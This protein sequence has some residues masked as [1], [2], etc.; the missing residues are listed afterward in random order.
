MGSTAG[1]LCWEKQISL[2]LV[3]E[4]VRSNSSSTLTTHPHHHPLPKLDPSCV[5]ET[6]KKPWRSMCLKST[7]TI[8]AFIKTDYHT[9]ID[10]S[11]KDKLGS[12]LFS[13]KSGGLIPLGSLQF[14]I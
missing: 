11:D 5:S 2:R 12:L 1:D 6:D 8:V 13:L 10:I 9:V 14:Q 4:V 7:H 3:G